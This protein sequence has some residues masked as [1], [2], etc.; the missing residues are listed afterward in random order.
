MTSDDLFGLPFLYQNEVTESI[1]GDSAFA[2]FAH[3]L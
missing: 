2:L 1:G 3:S